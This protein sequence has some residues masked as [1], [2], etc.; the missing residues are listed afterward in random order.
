MNTIEVENVE[1]VI[2]K[3]VSKYGRIE[4]LMQWKGQTVKVLV[5]SNGD[6]L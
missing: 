6:D 5:L 4:G 2:E 1:E 3:T